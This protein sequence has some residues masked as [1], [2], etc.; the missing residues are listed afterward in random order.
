MLG[1]VLIEGP[2][3][4]QRLAS[5]PPHRTGQ[6]VDVRGLF[7]PRGLES[8]LGIIPGVHGFHDGSPEPEPIHS[9]G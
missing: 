4:L 9:T 3:C 5:R 6:S 2:F 8:A 7:T 1:D